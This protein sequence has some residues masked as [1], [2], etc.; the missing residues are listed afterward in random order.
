MSYNNK[1]EITF[2]END[3]SWQTSNNVYTD[4]KMA[5]EERVC[6]QVIMLLPYVAKYVLLRI[7]LS[8]LEYSPS[9]TVMPYLWALQG[10]LCHEQR[11]A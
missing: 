3:I 6:M 11:I 8:S 4:L 2:L 9:F 1:N 10:F 5:T 7:C